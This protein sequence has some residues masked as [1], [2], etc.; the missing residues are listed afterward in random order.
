MGKRQ[1]AAM[2]TRTKVILAAEKLIA[3]HGFENV[4]IDDIAAKAGVAK[5][6]F[7]TYFKRKEDIIGE[8]A[9]S[10]FVRME[11]KSMEISGDVCDRLALFLSDSMKYIVDTGIH[12]CRQWLKNAVEP[13]NE[14]GKSKLMYDR[15]VIRE[16][17]KRAI[18]NEE[19]AADTPID[20][21]EMWI[22]A[23][24]YGFV[25]CWTIL[26]GAVDP[27]KLLDGYCKVQLR[28]SLSPYRI[29]K[30]EIYNEND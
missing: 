20:E 17:L 25:V 29:I 9:H 5:G 11:E 28:N 2:Q 7:Y 12:I 18:D 14:V 3:E 8:I 6:T 16:I 4:T 13:D 21:L 19:L 24:Y 22:A 10:N 1:I 26:D 30:E 27:V 15:S 23:E